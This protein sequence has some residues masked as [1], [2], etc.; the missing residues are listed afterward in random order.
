MIG[1]RCSVIEGRISW[2]FPV[3]YSRADKIAATRAFIRHD[4]K[5]RLSRVLMTRLE[6]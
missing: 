5:K 3:K 6:F 1:D 2:M 4:A